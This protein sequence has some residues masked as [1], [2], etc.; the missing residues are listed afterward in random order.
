M[1]TLRKIVTVSC[2]VLALLLFG[3]TALIAVQG[4]VSAD[5]AGNHVPKEANNI[6]FDFEILPKPPRS[7]SSANEADVSQDVRL[8]AGEIVLDHYD[9]YYTYEGCVLALHLTPANSVDLRKVLMGVLLRGR[10]SGIGMTAGG[11]SLSAILNTAEDSPI[12]QDPFT[13]WVVFKSVNL[14]R[15]AELNGEAFASEAAIPYVEVYL[16]F[17]EGLTFAGDD[18]ETGKA[19]PFI[20]LADIQPFGRN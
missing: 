1:G 11:G 13:V 7:V 2:T 15:I 8:S 12:R 6:L 18:S 14:D 9:V 17:Q 10:E 16:S 20:R 19:S 5:R 4:P 3:V